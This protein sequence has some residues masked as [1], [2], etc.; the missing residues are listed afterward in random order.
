MVVFLRGSCVQVTSYL[1]WSLKDSQ[2][3]ATLA[4]PLVVGDHIGWEADRSTMQRELG[5]RIY[6]MGK[7][8]VD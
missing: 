5:Y 6:L 2:W 7:E 3:R 8:I 4:D 1:E